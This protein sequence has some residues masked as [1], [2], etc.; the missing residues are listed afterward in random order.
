MRRLHGLTWAVLLL[1][2][3]TSFGLALA[4]GDQHIGWSEVL[5]SLFDDGSVRRESA[6]IIGQLRLPRTLLAMLVGAALA[7]G[8]A[9][10]QAMM[11]NPLA[12]PA[13]LGVNAG[14]AL[15]AMIVIVQVDVIPHTLLPWLTFSGALAMSV[16]LF[17]LALGAGTSSLSI[18]LIG[19]G[20][21]A[22]AGGAAGFIS[23]F[24]DVAKVQRAM[25]WLAG[26][27]Q[28]SRWPVV[29]GLALWLILPVAA[30]FCAHRELDLI[31]LGDQ[32]AAGRGQN[33]VRTK[34]ALILLCALMS[35][36]AVAAAGLIAFVGL[37]APHLARQ[38]VGR[39]HRRMLPAAAI[40]GAIMVVLADVAARNAMPPTQL[41]V[42][43]T[44][45]LLG[46]PFLG[47]LL[48]K[49]RNG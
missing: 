39:A 27:L 32:I 37:A 2:L 44:T 28:D 40:I 16:A 48:W 17:A 8:G 46:A 6:F 45:A 41:P 21:S 36:A 3:A 42:G 12:E 26:S 22:L 24:G 25:M 13:L 18:I 14:A 20:L 49:R 11:R 30:I 5:G 19:I 1:V 31:E 35:G 47:L 33:V 23:F 15:A 7:L 38:L 10:C 34:G 29:E 4:F 43:L 9:I